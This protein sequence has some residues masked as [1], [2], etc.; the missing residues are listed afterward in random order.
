MKQNE[1][2]ALLATQAAMIIFDQRD[3][4]DMGPILVTLEHAVAVVL[5]AMMKGDARKAARMLNEGLVPGIEQ[6]LLMYE[7]K[8]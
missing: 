3:P 7:N 2:D 1:R 6:R 8:D 4:T 5:I